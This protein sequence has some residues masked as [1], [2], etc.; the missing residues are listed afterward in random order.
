MQQRVMPILA[1]SGDCSPS[2]AYFRNAQLGFSRF[3]PK[4]IIGEW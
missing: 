2:I 3:F 1:I 4:A